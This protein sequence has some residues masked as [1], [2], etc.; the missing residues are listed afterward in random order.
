ME[1]NQYV[2]Q[3]VRDN[4]GRFV[5]GHKTLSD[6]NSTL[7]AWRKNGGTS[8]NSGWHHTEEAKKKIGLAARRKYTVEQRRNMGLGKL[9]DKN[10]QWRGGI[11]PVHKVIRRSTKFKEWRISV[12]ER[13]DYTCQD[14]GIRGGT[15]HPDHIKPFAY[16]PESRFD[17]NNGRTLCE[18]CHRKT[19]TWGNR[20]Q[21]LAKQLNLQT[22]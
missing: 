13:D 12:F 15:L 6:Y 10:P 11:T 18:N 3:G 5:V 4:R 9:G 17:V 20:G 14:C 2:P 1:S 22:V 7:G 21:Q 19:E 16:F 8:N